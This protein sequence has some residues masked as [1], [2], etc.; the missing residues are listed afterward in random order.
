MIYFNASILKVCLTFF[1]FLGVKIP[2]HQSLLL[3]VPGLEKE[4]VGKLV[5]DHVGSS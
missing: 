4:N 3:C 5:L 2:T 1:F